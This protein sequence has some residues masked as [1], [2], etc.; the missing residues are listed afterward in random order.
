MF[1]RLP[2]KLK[3]K[4]VDEAK[5]AAL[6]ERVPEPVRDRVPPGQFVTNGWPVLHFGGV[7]RF[8]E[9]TWSFRAWGHVENP[10]TLDYR[11]FRDLPTVERTMDIHCVTRWSKLDMTWEGVSMRHLL[12]MIRPTADARFVIAH[13]EAG[14]TANL[15]I[16]AILDDEVLLAHRADGSDLSLDHGW[17]LRLVVPARYFWKSAK[18]LRGLEFVREDQPGFW[19]QNGYHNDADPWKEERHW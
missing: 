16:S 7:P 14:F 8:V 18:W 4:G 6:R 12:D 10:V 19:E 15:P 11:A 2:A 3:G 13:C 9:A 17:P 1:F 5:V